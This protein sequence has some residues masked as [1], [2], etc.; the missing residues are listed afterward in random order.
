MEKSEHSSAEEHRVDT[1]Q[2]GGSNPSARTISNVQ[3]VTGFFSN[4]N[5]FKIKK[6]FKKTESTVLNLFGKS[7][8]D[9]LDKTQKTILGAVFEQ[10]LRKTFKL[11]RGKLDYVID[12]IDVDVKFS[13]KDSWMIPPECVGEICILASLDFKNN[14]NAFGI[15]NVKELYLNKGANRDK[16]RTISKKY[17]NKIKWIL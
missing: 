6:C 16:K 12:S 5:H 9:K 8:I 14:G 11:Q 7:S 3:R 13:I 15:I 4:G 2:V 17:Y 10:R 1:A